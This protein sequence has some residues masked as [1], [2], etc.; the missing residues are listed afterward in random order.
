SSSGP[1]SLSHLMKPDVTAPGESVL[2]SLPRREGLWGL[3]SGTSMAAPH[4]AGASAVLRQRHPDWTVAQIKS[5]LASTGDPVWTDDDRT[6]ETVTTREGGGR[7]DLPRADDPLVFTSQTG[8]AFGLVRPGT[9]R[10]LT[11][12]VTP[13][14]VAGS[15]WN[16][17]VQPQVQAPGVT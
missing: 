6:T 9:T 5:A 17:A 10:A 4:V 14:G 15:T 1:T 16:V 12:S 8:L 7:I 2:S 11:L 3:L 13:V